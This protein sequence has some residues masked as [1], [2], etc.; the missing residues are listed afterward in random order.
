M[1]YFLK[2]IKWEIMFPAV[3]GVLTIRQ[4]K[5]LV[6]KKI[7]FFLKETKQNKKP[8]QIMKISALFPST[9][10]P[11]VHLSAHLIYHPRHYEL[12]FEQLKYAKATWLRRWGFP[13]RDC[14]TKSTWILHQKAM[15]RTALRNTMDC[16][17][18]PKQ[19]AWKLDHIVYNVKGKIFP[20]CK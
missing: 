20:E 2:Y 18:W 11:T 12:C 5:C 4:T 3:V 7:L 15:T 13:L 6:K 8:Q 1:V 10:T 16:R 9:E 14:K 19:P 17:T